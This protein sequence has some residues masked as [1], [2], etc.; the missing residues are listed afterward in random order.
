[1]TIQYRQ[2]DVFIE[3]IDKL[4][5]DLDE[6]KDGIVLRGEATGHSHRLEGGQ[7][8]IGRIS[9]WHQPAEMFIAI[10]SVGRLVHEEHATIIIPEG[11]YKIRRQ[12]EYSPYGNRNVMD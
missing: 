10:P 12:V 7:V 5:K 8:L 2:G 11:F 1:M 6:V 4:P 3:K 9:G